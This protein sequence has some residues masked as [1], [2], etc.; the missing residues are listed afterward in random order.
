MSHLS[1][2]ATIATDAAYSPLTL[3]DDQ[4]VAAG[5]EGGEREVSSKPDGLE[6]GAGN[7]VPHLHAS[8]LAERRW[9]LSALSD[10]EKEETE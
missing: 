4:E 6:A 8:Q 7:S 3:R 5:G 2:A 1:K 9:R 10:G